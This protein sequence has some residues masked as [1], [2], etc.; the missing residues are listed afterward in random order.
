[1]T[2]EQIDAIRAN[3]QDARR[4]LE[5]LVP[6]YFSDVNAPHEM[7]LERALSDVE[8]LLA[9][10]AALRAYVDSHI[11]PPDDPERAA[12][13]ALVEALRGIAGVHPDTCTK[14]WTAFGMMSRAYRDAKAEVAGTRARAERYAKLL[15]ETLILFGHYREVGYNCVDASLR[16][17]AECRKLNPNYPITLS[18]DMFL[19]QHGLLP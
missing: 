5:R 2:D 19:R 7:A 8:A 17:I 1:M 3:R 9:E 14:V 13:T 12:A 18:L 4:E 15:D 10:V 11:R 6:G 16:A